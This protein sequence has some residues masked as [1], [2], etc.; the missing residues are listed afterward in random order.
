ML[1][2]DPTEITLWSSADTLS[3]SS[4]TLT[5]GTCLYNDPLFQMQLA[6]SLLSSDIQEISFMTDLCTAEVNCYITMTSNFVQGTD[7]QPN[8]AISTPLQA[9]FVHQNEILPLELQSANIDLDSGSLF[10][11]VNQEFTSVDVAMLTITKNSAN[12]TLQLSSPIQYNLEPAAG[13]ATIPLALTDIDQLKQV[14]ENPP[15]M[16]AWQIDFPE[17][18]VQAAASDLT[19]NETQLTLLILPD[20]TKPQVES[21]SLDMNMGV[22]TIMFNEIMSNAATT[23]LMFLTSTLSVPSPNN[24]TLDGSNITLSDDLQSFEITFTDTLFTDIQADEVIAKDVTTTF[25]YLALT[26]FFDVGGNTI[27]ETNAKEVQDLILETEP[28]TLVSFSMLVDFGTLRMTFS[29]PMNADSLALDQI[30][31]VVTMAHQISLSNDESVQFTDSNT[32]LT[33]VLTSTTLNELKLLFFESETNMLAISLT[34]GAISDSSNNN[35]V[36]IPSS[37]PL[38]ASSLDLDTMHPSL[39]TFSVISSPPQQYVLNFTFSEYMDLSSFDISVLTLTFESNSVGTS[40]YSLNG[41]ETV[42]IGYTGLTYELSQDDLAKTSLPEFYQIAYY[43]GNISILY[44]TELVTDLGGLIINAPLTPTKYQSMETDQSNAPSLTAFSL[45]LDA[46]TIRLNFTEPVVPLGAPSTLILANTLPVP[47]SSLVIN[48]TSYINLAMVG[49]QSFLLTLDDADVNELL[50]NEQFATDTSNTFILVQPAFGIDLS[51]NNIAVLAD[52]TQANEV[53]VPII[54]EPSSNI[55]MSSTMPQTTTSTITSSPSSSSS[56]IVVPSSIFEPMSSIAILSSVDSITPSTLIMSSIFSTSGES[57]V[58]TTSD[59]TTTTSIILSSSTT[60]QSTSESAIASSILSSPSGTESPSSSPSSSTQMS[61]F[62]TPSPTPIFSSDITINITQLDLNAGI[63]TVEFTENILLGQVGKDG[64]FYLTNA[65]SEYLLTN[66]DNVF[67]PDASTQDSIVIS[68]SNEDLLNIKALRINSNWSLEVTQGAVVDVN[69]REITPQSSNFTNFVSDT[70]APELTIFDL[71]LNN[72]ELKVTFDEPIEVN[73]VNVS[74]MYI[75]SMLVNSPFGYNLEGSFVMFDGFNSFKVFLSTSVLNDIKFDISVATTIENTN[76][77]VQGGQ[78][79]DYYNNIVSPVGLS[80]SANALVSDMTGPEL[81]SYQLDLNSG[82]II[83]T[84]TEPIIDSS[85]NTIGAYITNNPL[86]DSSSLS[87]PFTGT[88]IGSINTATEISLHLGNSIEDIKYVLY[89]VNSSY[90]SIPS[91]FV[92]DFSSNSVVSIAEDNPIMATF[93]IPDTTV[94]EAVSITPI[95]NSP[96]DGSITFDFNEYMLLS[97]MNE[98]DVVITIGN[99][100]YSGFLGGVWSANTNG[101]VKYQFSGED[102]SQ[103]SFGSD[104]IVA[105]NAGQM[106]VTFGPTFGSDLGSNFALIPLVHLTYLV[107]KDDVTPPILTAFDLD[108]DAGELTLTFSE[109][110]ILG[111]LSQG[112]Q[113]Q[114][115]MS[116]P[117][118]VYILTSSDSVEIS[119]GMKIVIM[120]SSNDTSNL[121]NITGFAN[122]IEDTFIQPTSQLAIDYSGNNLSTVG[123]IQASSVLTPFTPETPPQLLQTQLDL[124]TGNLVLFFDKSVQAAATKTEGIVLTN[125][126]TNITLTGAT[127]SVGQ[128][129][130]IINIQLDNDNLNSIKYGVSISQLSFNVSISSDSVFNEDMI[131]NVQQSATVSV[132]EDVLSPSV[133]MFSLNMD[134]GTLFVTFSEPMNNVTYNLSNVWLSGSAVNEPTGYQLVNGQVTGSSNESTIFM[135][136]ITN[137]ILN[138]IKADDSVAVTFENSYLFFSTNAFQDIFNNN[139]M[140]STESLQSDIFIADQTPPSLDSFNLDLDNGEMSFTFN[141]PVDIDSFDP[142]NIKVFNSDQTNNVAV[143]DFT[144]GNSGYDKMAALTITSDT[145]NNLKVIIGTSGQA[146]VSMTESTIKDTTANLVNAITESNPQLSSNIVQ[147]STSPLITSFTVGDENDKTITL[148]FNEFVQPTSWNGNSLTMTF[149]SS[150]GSNV[151]SGFSDGDVSD[152]V[153]NSITYTISDAKF[154]PLLSIHYQQAYYSGSFG[155]TFTSNLIQDVSSNQI[156]S[157]TQPIYYNSNNNDPIKPQLVSFD[158]DLDSSTLVMTFSEQIIINNVK[159]NIKFQNSASTPSQIFILTSDSYSSQNGLYGSVVTIVMTSSDVKSLTNNG[160]LASSVNDTYLVANTELGADYSGNLLVPNGVGIQASSFM[161]LTGPINPRI[162]SFD[163]DLDSDQLTFHF[164][165]PVD[166]STFVSSRITLVNESSVGV[167]TYQMQLSN[168]TVIAQGLQEDFRILLSTSN[169]VDIKRNPLCYTTDNCYAT[170]AEG[171]ATSEDNL[172]SQA[173]NSPLQ[174]S[175]LS[176]DVTPPRFLSFP[177]FDLNSGFF[178]IIFS[179]PVNGSS[180][181]FTQVQFS[182]TMSNPAESVTLNGGFTSPDHVELDFHLTNDDLNQIKYQLNLCTQASNCWLRLPSFTLSDIGSN[183]FL[184]SNY[185]PG[186]DASYHKPTVFVSDTTSPVLN[187][188][189]VD[190]HLGKIVFVF[191]EVIDEADFMPSDVTVLNK[192]SGD[193][194]LVLSN[195]TEVSVTGNGTHLELTF[196]KDDLNWLKSRNLFSSIEDSFVSLMTSM[197]DVSGNEFIDIGTDAAK[198]VTEFIRDS[199]NANLVSFELFNID[200]GSLILSFDEPVNSSSYQ[201]SAVTIVGDVSSVKYQLTGGSAMAITNE[202]TLIMITLSTVDR[203][204]IKLMSGLAKSYDNTFIA[205]VSYAIVDTFENSNQEVSLTSA[206]QLSDG[207]KYVPDTSPSGLL[208]FDINMNTTVLTLT[209]DDVINVETFE[210]KFI[211]I[212]NSTDISIS[213][214]YTLDD[215]MLVSDSSNIIMIKIGE[216]DGTAIKSQLQLAKSTENTY[217]SFAAGIAM[218]IEGRFLIAVPNTNALRVSEYTPDTTSPRLLS[219]NLDLDTGDIIMTFNEPM[220]LSSFTPN[221]LTF[222]N[223]ED[224]PTSTYTIQ[225]GEVTAQ[226]QGAEADVILTLVLS[227][228]DLNEVKSN[229]NLATAKTNSYISVDPSLIVDAGGNNI[230]FVS[231]MNS[232]EYVADITLPTLIESSLDMTNGGKLI[233]VFSEAVQYTT[234]LST[235][236]RIQNTLTNPT[237]VIFLQDPSNIVTKTNLHEITVTLSNVNTNKINNDNSIAS[238]TSNAFISITAGGIFDYSQGGVGQSLASTTTRITYIC[239]CFEYSIKLQR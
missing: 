27:N 75:T 88:V 44:T 156:A 203:V 26:S 115:S 59:S 139:L 231:G 94:P 108:T 49:V 112:L 48:S 96:I 169:I 70:T 17:N 122:T 42:S 65:T 168:T 183:P 222:Q 23:S 5:G 188:I 79:E 100:N 178:T 73:S 25:L 120:L 6:I 71:D 130:T 161:M 162:S 56:V 210:P 149:N 68:L 83:L 212:Q 234:I 184:H 127:A 76:L 189:S 90:L 155:I 28:P 204:A 82:V 158:L 215:S 136:E 113:L 129:N 153:T 176:Q 128:N 238:S 163:L 213:T 29:E 198:Q 10:I 157:L 192:P 11:Q 209:F 45:D 62:A 15:N 236:V 95:A 217:I 85:I 211:T 123:T 53:I 116:N 57:S 80:T 199:G 142:T 195:S 77:Y 52:G 194:S 55:V 89:N 224:N 216:K 66:L 31:L 12:F 174:V 141:E 201:P 84:F 227:S 32:L 146:Y 143:N 187:E 101:S 46:G 107:T 109:S 165:T 177:V 33:I 81:Q 132:I 119:Y 103:N 51:G 226:S 60:S 237:E 110:V 185:Q 190:M 154:Q 137:A 37:N 41:G 102:L 228:T 147:D 1:A 229:T 191:N 14:V 61:V 193:I 186:A 181:D 78:L 175:I 239:K 206:A 24:Y 225:G 170:F 9:L 180:T 21:F 50:A 205:L 126:I 182:D 93:V 58:L 159:D 36:S 19:F 150:I 99:M 98:S 152:I 135:V 230:E 124:N 35:I 202:K 13:N 114:N 164:D 148:V 131:G 133:L 125:G 233:M 43:T 18:A 232:A 8:Q 235:S 173:I 7:N 172:P 67:F 72:G 74:D 105:V 22:L 16:T 39:M 69:S 2:C 151:Y 220:L 92:V 63:L 97:S 64:E 106:S 87:T 86:S 3:A 47:V 111:P 167:N 200:N 179:E 160:L 40:Q 34:A 20:T 54:I 140:E 196:T 118:N 117:T 121:L 207:S 38:Q 166:V 197:G 138:D 208:L 144:I 4:Y 91:T 219:Y 214:S 221:G 145:L 171:V 30:T 134:N 223:T 218:D 104:Y